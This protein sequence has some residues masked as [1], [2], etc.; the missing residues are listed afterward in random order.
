MRKFTTAFLRNPNP[1]LH[2]HALI[3][4]KIAASSLLFKALATGGSSYELANPEEGEVSALSEV[5]MGVLKA[6]KKVEK[7]ARRQKADSLELDM[8]GKEG[9]LLAEISK[10]KAKTRAKARPKLSEKPKKNPHTNVVEELDHIAAGEKV[11]AVVVKAEDAAEKAEKAALN[12]KENASLIHVKEDIAKSAAKIDVKYSRRWEET[13]YTLLDHGISSAHVI[14]MLQKCRKLA[15]GRSVDSTLM[16]FTMLGMSYEDMGRAITRCPTI[17]NVANI[18]FQRKVE[19]FESIGIDRCNLGKIICIQPIAIKTSLILLQKN[20]T[21]WKDY[22][23]DIQENAICVLILKNPRLLTYN[24]QNVVKPKIAYLDEQG[25]DK[26]MLFKRSSILSCSLE[27]IASKVKL[28]EQFGMSNARRRSWSLAVLHSIS[29]PNLHS[30]FNNLILL[31]FS[32]DQVQKILLACP[33][34]LSL[35]ED[36]INLKVSYAVN[37]MNSSLDALAAFPTYLLHSY[38]KRIKFRYEVIKELTTLGALQG[39][40][41]LRYIV[42]MTDVDFT[43]RFVEKLQAC[44][45]PLNA[46]N[47]WCGFIAKLQQSCPSVCLVWK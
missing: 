42:H 44:G 24:L 35:R 17:L 36:Y 15:C 22:M 8:G 18:S 4:K 11:I 39:D 10:L 28:L 29:I 47:G 2:S 20:C 19:F 12:V 14:K 26:K 9:S 34:V 1:S 21:F 37:V 23:E 38:N 13:A 27:A 7:K 16:H 25:F 43:R 46:P 30:R 45:K 5:S 33:L 41:S 3:S 40:L 6:K 32:F 31:G